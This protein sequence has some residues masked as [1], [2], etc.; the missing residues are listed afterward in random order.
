MKPVYRAIFK[1]R[2]E[3]GSELAVVAMD[4]DAVSVF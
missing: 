4:E 1:V 3:S 2:D